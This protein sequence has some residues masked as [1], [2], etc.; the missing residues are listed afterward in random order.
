MDSSLAESQFSVF[1]PPPFAIRIG[2]VCVHSLWQCL[3]V[4]AILHV[5]LRLIPRRSTAQV[6][7]RYL[8][9]VAALVALPL[10]SATTYF[11]SDAGPITKR[12]V[13]QPASATPLTQ[14]VDST[15]TSPWGATD[16]ALAIGL[17][18]AR[19]QIAR[20]E[21]WLPLVSVVWFV[22]AFLAG[23]RMVA[24][25][26]LSRRLVA[27]AK[28]ATENRWQARVATWCEE[29][30]VNKAVRFLVSDAID[31]P[32][33]VGWL[34]PVILWPTA[35]LH[36]M[37]PQDVEAIIAHE[38]A[39]IRRGDVL[40]NLL[41]ACIEVLFFHH[42][43]AWWISAQIRAEREYCADDLAV[44]M[45]DRSESG[46]KLSYAR[47][48][49]ALE[50]HRSIPLL[51]VAAKGGKLLDRIRRLVGVE[52]TGHSPARPL[53]GGLVTT[54]LLGI[55]LAGVFVTSPSRAI[56]PR[57]VMIRPAEAV[58]PEV[59][60]DATAD[61][62]RPNLP[63]DSVIEATLIAE[64]II[65]RLTNA[66]VP[67]EPLRMMTSELWGAIEGG[68]P[69]TL[70]QVEARLEELGIARQTL[71]APP[72]GMAF[73]AKTNGV[74]PIV[75]P[76]IVS[77]PIAMSVTARLANAGVD[78]QVLTAIHDTMWDAIRAGNPINLEQ[79]HA[80]LESLGVPAE[81][82]HAPPAKLPPGV[83]PPVIPPLGATN[84]DPNLVNEPIAL[85]V[86]ARL[87]KAGVDGKT[88]SAIRD[89]MWEAI[90]AGNP[91]TLEQLHARLE[92]LGLSAETLHGPPK[93]GP[94]DQTGSGPE[95]QT[96]SGPEDQT[97]SGPEDQTGS[98]PEDQTGSGPEEPTAE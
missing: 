81:M 58:K 55:L 39:H 50:E 79:L 29:L 24:G 35:A 28:V 63:L 40:I 34:K 37:T 53:V 30:G 75:D 9:S 13:E 1:L 11:A 78:P 76:N 12:H 20:I 87:S 82:L 57:S 26:A 92:S 98:G 43:A 54:S 10:L 25:W 16:G 73:D 95:D 97:G 14:G 65:N 18:V 72:A 8:L 59:D 7:A 17:G 62:S 3:L 23:L 22:G 68:K 5:A 60:A 90:R 70:R 89:S 74:E 66:G 52:T 56:G 71:L 32:L 19:V 2:W 88:M 67:P 27:R 6:N 91:L 46:T 86:V 45:L 38:L 49:L 41:Q 61:Q 4:A 21:P 85:A 93:R 31:S 42:P 80:R 94:E 47:A 69:L 83:P 15:S 48:L 84:V 51:S 44:R 77:E 96:G 36:G 33:V 64:A